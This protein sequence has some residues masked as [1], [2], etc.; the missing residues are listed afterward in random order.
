MVKI[1]K[2][3]PSKVVIVPRPSGSDD[4]TRSIQLNPVPMPDLPKSD[5][6]LSKEVKDK[7]RRDAEPVTNQTVDKLIRKPIEETVRNKK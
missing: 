2:E 4:T 5:Q 6:I 3:N 7:L 1:K